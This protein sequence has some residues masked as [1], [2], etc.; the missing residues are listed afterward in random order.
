[1][2]TMQARTSPAQITIVDKVARIVIAWSKHA[3]INERQ[4]TLI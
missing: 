2:L 4:I 3:S 1:M